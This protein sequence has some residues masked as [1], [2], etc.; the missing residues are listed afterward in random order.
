MEEDLGAAS[1]ARTEEPVGQ[2]EDE[3]ASNSLGDFRD[4]EAVL[5]KDGS[6]MQSKGKK[7]SSGRKKV[8]GRKNRVVERDVQ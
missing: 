3:K 4:V 2:E 6:K 7:K 1:T 5:V 8:G